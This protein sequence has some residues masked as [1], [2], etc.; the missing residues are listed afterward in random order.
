VALGLNAGFEPVIEV[1][2]LTSVYF[3]VN[4]RTLEV[5]DKRVYVVIG[6]QL[7]LSKVAS[8]VKLAVALVPVINGSDPVSAG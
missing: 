8:I 3:P 1:R 5:A 4:W 7:L 6:N 2:I